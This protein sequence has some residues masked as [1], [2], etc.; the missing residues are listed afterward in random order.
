MVLLGAPLQK[1]YMSI[2][3]EF[4]TYMIIPSFH[5][6][7][8]SITIKHPQKQNKNIFY[9]LIVMHVKSI[10]VLQVIYHKHLLNY[11]LTSSY[12]S[13]RVPL[14]PSKLLTTTDN[15][16]RLYGGGQSTKPIDLTTPPND[17]DSIALPVYTINAIVGVLHRTQPS[18]NHPKWSPRYTLPEQTNPSVQEQLLLLPSTCNTIKEYTQGT[19]LDVILQAAPN[20]DI[21]LTVE[22]LRNLVTYNTMI[23]HKILILSLEN[24]CNT[25]GSK[26]LDPSF[27]PQLRDHG[28]SGVQHYFSCGR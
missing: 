5:S 4:S 23:Y 1:P 22:G 21:H 12:S 20:P 16:I 7:N 3:C 28:W 2:C 18:A 25:T 8:P 17:S 27:L 14:S 6:D 24:I 19:R 11:M 15:K 26:Y 10:A 9:I 13:Y